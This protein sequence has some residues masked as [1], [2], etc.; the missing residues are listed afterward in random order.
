M[1]GGLQER[2]TREAPP[3]SP[4]RAKRPR[5]DPAADGAAATAEV[6]ELSCPICLE[7]AA[8]VAKPPCGHVLCWTC[9]HQLFGSPAANKPVRCP[10]CRSE[11]EERQLQSSP[12][13]DA[14]VDRLAAEVLDDGARADWAQRKKDGA[15][16][17]ARA[18]AQQNGK[19]VAARSSVHAKQRAEQRQLISLGYTFSCAPSSRAVCRAESCKQRIERGRLRLDHSTGFLH[20][21]CH[22]F[23]RELDAACTAERV[24]VNACSELTVTMAATVQ[25]PHGLRLKERAQ[26]TRDIESLKEQLRATGGNRPWWLTVEMGGNLFAN[27]RE[28]VEEGDSLLR[29]MDDVMN[30]S[31]ELFESGDIAAA[32]AECEGAVDRLRSAFGGTNEHTLHAQLLLANLVAK[33]GRLA[34]SVAM[35][36][37]VIDQFKQQFGDNNLDT[38]GAQVDL[39][40]VLTRM[41]R[42]H[43]ARTILAAVLRE[44]ESQLGAYHEDTMDARH[45]LAN[46]LHEQ[47]QLY[48]AKT[49]YETLLE[50]RRR[51]DGEQAQVTMGVKMCLANVLMQ[52]GRLESSLELHEEVVGV[53]TDLLGPQHPDTHSARNNLATVRDYS[54]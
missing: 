28:E 9:S 5:S 6:R 13:I 11:L 39:A 7:L 21:G 34:D 8:F 45:A 52:Q 51:H 31:I 10:Q 36:G 14:L 24:G 26:W 25:P 43:E 53:L 40:H 3:E 2:R 41:D 33:N 48:V 4:R 23:Q 47:G 19:Q 50:Q 29:A 42:L 12:E 16:L 22:D 15:G 49:M 30:H 20:A 1:P 18:R 46:L 35:Y 54:D 32:V 44:Y 38:L 17:Y 37:E 27:E